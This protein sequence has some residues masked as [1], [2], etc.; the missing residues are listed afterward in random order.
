MISVIGLTKLDFKITQSLVESNKYEKQVRLVKKD[1][2]RNTLKTNDTLIRTML[3]LLDFT[4]KDNIH[5]TRA[6]SPKLQL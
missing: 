5:G 4:R 3:A 1:E 2:T 6:T